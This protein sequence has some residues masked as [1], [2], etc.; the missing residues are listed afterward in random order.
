MNNERES[1]H[2][3]ELGC[4]E[5]IAGRAEWDHCRVENLSRKYGPISVFPAGRPVEVVLP[6]TIR[7]R[8][9]GDF[10]W[11]WYH[12]CMI[13]DNLLQ[14]F[15]EHKFTGF[16]VL[17]VEA[18][19]RQVAQS[20]PP[21]VIRAASI[22]EP[23]TEAEVVKLWQLVV[24]G[25][26]GV[27]SP[28][29]GIEVREWREKTTGLSKPI[30]TGLRDSEHLMDESQWDG[31]DFFMIWPLPCFIFV[32]GRVAKLIKEYQLKGVVLRRL[33]DF[34]QSSETSGYSPGLLRYWM[35]E[36]RAREIGEPLGIY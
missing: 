22:Q 6:I 33:K 19:V 31:S 7:S 5:S 23:P 36:E 27:A 17:P 32:S 35:P 4:P 26:G 2:F 29:S 25:W 34:H 3:W 12:E 28:E 1:R 16:D 15:R 24:T 11:T 21:S 18:R 20:R 10:I 9:T 13:Q 14:L 30:Y 8:R